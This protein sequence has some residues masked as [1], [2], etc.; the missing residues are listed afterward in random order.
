MIVQ[1]EHF[2]LSNFEGTL[3]FLLCLLQKDEIDIYQIPILELIDQFILKI[4]ETQVS[5]LT[6]GAE[7]I[8]S[9][10]YLVWLK[11]KMLLP[12]SEQ[13]TN[14]EDFFEDPSF[15]I[16]HHLVEYSRF[17]QA[18]K[19]LVVRQEKQ[20]ACYFRGID[21]PPEWKK[22]LGIDHV[23]LDE[24]SELFRGMMAK[25]SQAKTQIYEEE[26]R[27]S[28]KM[29]FI[30]SRLQMENAFALNEML[31][32]YHSKAELIVTFLA[33]LELMKTGELAVGREQNS[34]NLCLYKPSNT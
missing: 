13:Q 30:R 29:A 7:F 22:P 25:A 4:R 18:A 17:K 12:Q 14:E 10:A 6:A 9:A 2:T 1:N 19:E 3:E 5:N 32:N 20:Q 28:D 21:A 24:L 11:S 8:G 34:L 23:S 16:I 31:T 33:I 26:W 15:E 27:V